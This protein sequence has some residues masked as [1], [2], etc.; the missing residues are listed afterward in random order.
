M[1]IAPPKLPKSLQELDVSKAL[2]EDNYVSD[3]IVT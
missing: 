3:G 1:K 2:L